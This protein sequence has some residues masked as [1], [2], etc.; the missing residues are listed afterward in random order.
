MDVKYQRRVAADMLKC[1]INRVWVSPEHLDEVAD[2][3]TREDIRELIERNI[4]QK[5]KKKGVS[6]A[7]ARHI[8]EQKKKGRRKGPGSRKGKKYA[9]TSKK[10]KW[11]TMIRPIRAEL[12]S[13]RDSEQISR[14]DYRIYYR[15]A[16]GGMYKSKSHLRLHL[17]S[18]GHLKEE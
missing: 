6:R 13:L 9:G 2:A 14:H 1:G 15:R 4:I 12:K 8:A 11:M 7:R 5:K 18:D 10:E 17:R 3:I 16:K